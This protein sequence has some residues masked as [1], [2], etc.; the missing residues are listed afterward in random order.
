MYSD[1]L[2]APPLPTT[3]VVHFA[4]RVEG[5]EST[6]SEAY[7]NDWHSFNAN[8]LIHGDDE[9]LFVMGDEIVEAWPTDLIRRIEWFP[10]RPTRGNW[11]AEKRRKHR[12]A[13]QRW[14]AEEDSLLRAE[15]ADGLTVGEMAERHERNE[16][17]ITARLERLGLSSEPSGHHLA[18]TDRGEQ[19]RYPAIVRP[20]G[21]QWAIELPDHA[22]ARAEVGDID[23]VAIVAAAALSQRLDMDVTPDQIDVVVVRS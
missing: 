11:L 16:A 5:P 21:E 8:G 22:D 20:A 7:R 6:A 18:P 10:S 3:V 12:R 4:D 13:Y 17:A 14:T 23:E 9:T 15:K 2:Q 1:V 19:M